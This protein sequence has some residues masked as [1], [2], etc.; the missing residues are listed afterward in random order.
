MIPSDFPTP[1][2]EIES[3]QSVP[4]LLYATVIW[5]LSKIAY[6]GVAA[7]HAFQRRI[8]ARHKGESQVLVNRSII[9][10]ARQPG[11]RQ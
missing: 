3:F 6:D 2:S 7:A 1:L 11:Y 5:P 10:F 8:V 9:D 4:V